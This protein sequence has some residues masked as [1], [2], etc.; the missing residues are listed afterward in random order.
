MLTGHL[1]QNWVPSSREMHLVRL[2]YS[3]GPAGGDRSPASRWREMMPLRRDQITSWVPP[4]AVNSQ[5]SACR[6]VQSMGRM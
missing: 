6:T 2:V 3:M 5:T 4:T 1:W